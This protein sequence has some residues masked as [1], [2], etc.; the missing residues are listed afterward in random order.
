MAIW[1][2]SVPS[3]S[4]GQL[5]P[6]PSFLIKRDHAKREKPPA[7]EGRAEGKPPIPTT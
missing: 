3:L 2:H 7:F 5:A 6:A 4:A 1:A